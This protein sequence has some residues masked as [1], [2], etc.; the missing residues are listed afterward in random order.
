MSRTP[1]HCK[2]NAAALSFHTRDTLQR[3]SVQLEKYENDQTVLVS[4]SR[5]YG[6]THTVHCK[7]AS[8][9]SCPLERTGPRR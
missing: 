4:R 5:T 9:Q 6:Q 2:N 7:E 1:K 8:S 3:S